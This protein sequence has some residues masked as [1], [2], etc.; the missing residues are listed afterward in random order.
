LERDGTAEGLG[1]WVRENKRLKRRLA[2]A[3]LRMS[4]AY[5]K[6]V[7]FPAARK[8]DKAMIRQLGPC[9]WVEELRHPGYIVTILSASTVS[10]ASYGVD[11]G[12]SLPRPV[13]VQS[14]S[15]R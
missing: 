10:T 3:K 5:L 8:L 2:E 11:E 12:P 1:L 7:D 6:S 14:G 4:Q 15:H 13:L 9:R